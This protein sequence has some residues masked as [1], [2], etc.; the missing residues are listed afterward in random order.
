MKNKFLMEY[1]IRAIKNV[2]TKKVSVFL[3]PHIYIKNRIKD[4]I[5][6]TDTFINISR[7]LWVTLIENTISL[8]MG[9]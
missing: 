7:I 9:P 3:A 5:V 2:T 4:K 6:S 1:G 8:E